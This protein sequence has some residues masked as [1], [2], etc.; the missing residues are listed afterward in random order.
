[1]FMSCHPHYR[2]TTADLL[3]GLVPPVGEVEDGGQE[4]GGGHQRPT[5]AQ[6]GGH[7]LGAPRVTDEVRQALLRE[8]KPN[9]YVVVGSNMTF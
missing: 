4:E 5:E 8:G 3:P 1:M 6:G 9:T 2:S 7:R